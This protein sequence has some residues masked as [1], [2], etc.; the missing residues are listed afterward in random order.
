MTAPSDIPASEAGLAF[1]EHD[2][3]A[4][5][6]SALSAAETLCAERGKRLTPV[7]RR[8]LELLCESHVAMG[9]YDLLE[10]LAVDGLGSK[11]P[12]VY[13][14]L[15]FLMAEGLVHRIERLNA[16]VACHHATT[17][18]TP[19]LMVCRECRAVSEGSAEVPQAALTAAAE[20]L[21]FQLE[22]Q[23]IEAEGLCP[24]CQEAMPE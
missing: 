20:A 24:N 17:P 10:R 9:A 11:P 7:R 23:I 4:C 22:R 3:T 12:V 5:A 15:D 21:G 16:Y 19:L 1:H 6:S 18:H 13:R 8:V 2:H 14:A